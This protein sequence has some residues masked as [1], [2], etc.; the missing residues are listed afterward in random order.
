MPIVIIIAALAAIVW[1]SI[2][3]RRGSIVVGCGL[4]MIVG[5]VLGH[6]FWHAK[7]G[8]LPVTLDR[9]VLA[10]VVAAF[11]IQWRLGMV[12][13]KRLVGGD[14][15]LAA[16]LLVLTTS[17]LLNGQPEVA[18][19]DSTWGRL[20]FSYYL[21][22]LLY[23]IARQASLTRREWQLLLTAFV[24]L[25]TYLALTA[26]AEITG[27]WSFV[28]P[29]YIAN[30]NLGIHF[31]R[32]RGPNLN[33]ASLGIFLTACLWCGWC[34]LS[35]VV[36]PWQQLAILLVLPLMVLGVFLTYTRSAWLGLV[37]SG[38]VV[39]ALQIPRRWRFPVLTTAMLGGVL[40]TALSWGHL[41]G[42]QR[43][44]SAA[45]SHH[46]VDQRKSFA[47]VSWQMFKDHPIDGVGLGRF[48]DL[49]LPYLSDRRQEVE[50][51]SIRALNHHNTLLSFLVETGMLGLAA[52]LAVFVIWTKYAWQLAKNRAIPSWMRGQGILMLALLMTYLS[53][54][55]F[56]D[57]TLVMPQ[58]W[59]LFLFAG[60][61]T[62]L[63]QQ[64][65]AIQ[66]STVVRG[67]PIA[68]VE[69]ERGWDAVSIGSSNGNENQ[70]RV[71]PSQT[72]PV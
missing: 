39:A 68:R 48:Y 2:C 9:I 38:L 13:A 30:P 66:S 56:H 10:A 58:Q 22:S 20:A 36:R 59:L 15:L 29:R 67:T 8:P 70:P 27:K 64:A 46:S 65:P 21:S 5:Y 12:E 33:S 6:E 61:T 72:L 41:I 69:D 52:F 16:L 23:W 45:E 44:G 42:L 40:I 60:L 49:K 53:S 62:N 35:R 37:A 11:V 32:A 4:F 31:G 19:P 63:W 24:L 14:W 34:L 18:N 71:E 3:A 26:V 54:A 17:A 1:G 51:E 55:L 28:F 47:Y 43:E 7:I 57:L 25:G 50:L